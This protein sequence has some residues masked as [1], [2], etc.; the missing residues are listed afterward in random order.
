MHGHLPGGDFR[1][2]ALAARRL[3]QA[4][5]GDAATGRKPFDFGLVIGQLVIGDDL[6][7]AQAGTVVDLQKTE[8]A[9]RVAAGPDP[10]LHANLT[11]DRFRTASFDH[12]YLF[13]AIRTPI[14]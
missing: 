10:A 1:R 3:Y 12:A 14:S 6:Q 2:L 8:A 5:H 9:L 11:A 7:V 13:H 4:D